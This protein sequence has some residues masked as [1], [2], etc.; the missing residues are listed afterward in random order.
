[1]NTSTH[2]Q[3][4]LLAGLIGTA[5]AS[6]VALPGTSFAQASYATL[7]GKAPPN[8]QVTA[9]NPATGSKRVAT[10]GADGSYTITGLQP[11]TYKVDAGPGTEQ[12][13]TLTVASTS[14]L[15]LAAATPAGAANA[16][17]LSGVT[18]T[19]SVLPDVTTPEVG[20][21]VSLH[22]IDTIPQ[23][24]RNFLEFADTVPGMVFTVNSQGNTSLRGGAQND[25]STNV[26]ID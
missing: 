1:M 17:N 16:V 19:A 9:V 2:F 4:N 3:K 26:Y 18:V 12:T 15:N 10:A 6:L 22:Q 5:I 23:L 7:R 11:G 20:S 25:A 21:T 13:V 8:T 24:T 14:T